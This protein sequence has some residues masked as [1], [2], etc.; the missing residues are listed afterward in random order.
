MTRRT[1][2]EEKVAKILVYSVNDLTLDLDL[3]GEYVAEIST[4]VLYNRLDLVM[5]TARE[6]RYGDSGQLHQEKLDRLNS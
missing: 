4:T 3:V 1:T 2:K 6:E 5:E